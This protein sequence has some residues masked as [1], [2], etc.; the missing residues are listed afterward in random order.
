[1]ENIIQEVIE[2]RKRGRPRIYKPPKP[3]KPPKIPKPPKLP[4]IDPYVPEFERKEMI[5]K[6]Y[7][8]DLRKEDDFIRDN[9][10][11]E[12]S[13]LTSIEHLLHF[14]QSEMDRV[15]IMKKS[16]KETGIRP[17]LIV[18]RYKELHGIIVVLQRAKI[19]LQRVI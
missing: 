11:M 2:K 5:R 6:K 3:P 12:T 7:K 8:F 1:M 4:E 17:V 18:D 10:S 13:S 16:K 15:L 14:Y 19:V 9:K